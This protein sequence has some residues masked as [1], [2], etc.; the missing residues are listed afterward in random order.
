MI[1]KCIKKSTGISF[2]VLYLGMYISLILI[3]ILYIYFVCFSLSISTL[4][5]HDLTENYFLLKI[6]CQR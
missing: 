3:F 6:Q 5:A 4:N 1:L 2:S